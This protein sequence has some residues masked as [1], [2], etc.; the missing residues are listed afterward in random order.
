MPGITDLLHGALVSG[1]EMVDEVVADGREQTSQITMD[2][3]LANY[4][5]IR[6]YPGQVKAF[7]RMQFVRVH[8]EVGDL[9]PAEREATIRAEVR[10]YQA[11]MEAEIRRRGGTR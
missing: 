10:R 7:T 9:A 4:E 3:A 2:Q 11:A 1:R 5:Q 8:P 6:A